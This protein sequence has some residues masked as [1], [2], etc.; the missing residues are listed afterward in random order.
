MNFSEFFSV[1][2]N[3]LD[4]ACKLDQ[5]KCSKRTA[6]GNPWIRADQKLGNELYEKEHCVICSL[7]FTHGG[8]THC[9][10]TKCVRKFSIFCRA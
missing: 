10:S 4:I 8:S 6:K 1:S 2:N 9:D 5:P 7:C 3:Q